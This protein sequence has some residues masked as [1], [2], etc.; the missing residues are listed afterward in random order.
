MPF[1]DDPASCGPYCIYTDPREA[2]AA[3]CF[4]LQPSGAVAHL[5]P[6]LLQLHNDELSSFPPILLYP[7]AEF[8]AFTSFS[9]C[10]AFECFKLFATA[11]GKAQARV[12]RQK[13]TAFCFVLFLLC[14]MQ[15]SSPPALP[16]SVPMRVQE[17]RVPLGKKPGFTQPDAR[18]KL[19]WEQNSSPLKQGVVDLF[20]KRH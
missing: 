17:C 8:L 18:E 2:S 6:P 12:L 20:N 3:L 10:A 15:P 5:L 4:K 13:T 16:P 9:F 14:Q 11:A 7:L 1:F 19:T